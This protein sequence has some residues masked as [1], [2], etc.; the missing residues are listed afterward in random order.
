MSTEMRDIQNKVLEH[1]HKLSAMDRTM[2]EAIA[3]QRSL[4]KELHALTAKFGIYIERHDQVSEANKRLWSAFERQSNDLATLQ[5]IVS[6]NQPVIDGLRNLQG[7]LN[8]FIIVTALTPIAAG[9]ALV[10]KAVS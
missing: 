10:Y 3:E 5:S 7:K 4:V 2:M 6:T 1:E 9:A 8:W